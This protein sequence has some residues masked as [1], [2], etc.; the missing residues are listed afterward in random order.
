MPE[1]VNIQ[2]Y[3]MNAAALRKEAETELCESPKTRKKAL[4]ELRDWLKS[5]NQTL[6]TNQKPTFCAKIKKPS[7]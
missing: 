5:Q 4:R 2:S 7:G 1:K 6:A 3:T